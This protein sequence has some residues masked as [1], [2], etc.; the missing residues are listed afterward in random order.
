M[1]FFEERRREDTRNDMVRKVKADRVIKANAASEDRVSYKRSARRVAEERAETE[2]LEGMEAD[3]RRR[4]Q[5]ERSRAAEEALSAAMATLEMEKVRDEKFRAQIRETA[6]ELRDLEAKLKAGYTSKELQHQITARETARQEETTRMRSTAKE[7]ARA[8]ADYE[9]EQREQA[10][11]EHEK[12]MRYQGELEDQLAMQETR[13][14]DAYEQFLRDKAMID[15]IVLKIQEEDDEEARRKRDKMRLTREE[16]LAFEDERM[17][18]KQAMLDQMQKEDEI[19]AQQAAEQDAR[20]AGLKAA[21]AGQQAA[22]EELQQR[23]GAEAARARHEADEMD[24][25][26]QELYEEEMRVAVEERARADAAKRVRMRDELMEERERFL[27]R[28]A[29]QKAEEAREEAEFRAAMM[30]KFARDDKL[31]QMGAQ[32]RRMKAIEH[33]RAIEGLIE[34][35]RARIEHERAMESRASEDEQNRE[36]IRQQVIEEERQRMLR[37]HA[38]KLLGYLPKGVIKGDSDLDLLGPEFKER[39]TRRPSEDDFF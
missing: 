25:V 32:K 28:S 39:Y 38:V 18:Y 16:Q 24:R 23:M 22:L 10:M 1:R 27:E 15:D 5:V 21:K 8:E 11:R 37:E 35:R 30:E 34:E 4:A 20:D 9:A 33:R 3:A 14:R 6:P 26:R 13:R 31:E 36:A 29:A 19:I 17:A 12:T 7:L 2:Y